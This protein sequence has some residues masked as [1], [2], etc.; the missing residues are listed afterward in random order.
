MNEIFN[1]S[2][3]FSTKQT[4]EKLKNEVKQANKP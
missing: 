1:E 3:E 4:L 2:K